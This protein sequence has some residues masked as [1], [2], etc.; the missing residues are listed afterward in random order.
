MDKDK[1]KAIASAYKALGMDVPFFRDLNGWTG[2]NVLQNAM[3]QESFYE[4]KTNGKIMLARPILL[5]GIENNNGWIKMYGEHSLPKDEGYYWIIFN[6]GSTAICVFDPSNIF[7]KQIFLNS[8][9]YYQL[10]ITPSN[11]IY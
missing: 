6:T 2:V 7:E 5:Q 1:S 9:K 11:P 8:V 4:T 3:V 10:A